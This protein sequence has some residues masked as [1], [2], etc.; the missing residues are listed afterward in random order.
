VAQPDEA[1]FP[2]KCDPEKALKA[3]FLIV[4][5]LSVEASSV[6]ALVYVLKSLNL[7]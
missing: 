4:S 6:F 2:G 1:H 3:V 5:R 7:I